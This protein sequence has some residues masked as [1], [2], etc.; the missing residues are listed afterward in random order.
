[1]ARK[2]ES[3][4]IFQSDFK[5]KD[6]HIIGDKE[7]DELPELDDEML[8]RAIMKKAGRPFSSNPKKLISL[9]LAPDVLE[10]WKAT[11][12]GWQARMAEK[13]GEV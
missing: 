13:L 11:G 1:M 2:E 5:R 9:R 4:P 7:Y 12:A 3:F 6:A 10:K 8:S